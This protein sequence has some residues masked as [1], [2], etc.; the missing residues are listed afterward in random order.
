MPG[1][2]I[3]Y[4]KASLETMYGTAACN[5][6]LTDNGTMELHITIPPNT[7][8]EAILPAAKLEGLL[9]SGGLALKAEGIT[10]IEACE[11]GVKVALGSGSYIFSYA[12]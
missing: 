7:T 4:V 9:E 12:L 8:G 1:P 2:G 11:D 3:S 5:W 10:G 6:N